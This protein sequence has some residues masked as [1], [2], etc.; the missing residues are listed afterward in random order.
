MR[1][2]DVASRDP[3]EIIFDES[4]AGGRSV[5]EAERDE[6]E[7]GAKCERNRSTAGRKRHH[8]SLRLQYF[9]FVGS[10][11]L[12]ASAPDDFNEATVGPPK[13]KARRWAGG[14]DEL[15]RQTR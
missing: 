13:R 14:L 5:D 8:P 4:V 6:Q 9:S 3:S 1:G 7:A 10:V 2:A 12:P 11:R 15:K